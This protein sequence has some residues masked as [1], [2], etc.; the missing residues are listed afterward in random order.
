EAEKTSG[1]RVPIIAMTAQAMAGDVEN[2]LSA[3]MDA[4]LSKPVTRE[5]LNAEID[6]WCGGEEAQA[7]DVPALFEE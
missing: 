2:C 5:E 3:G 7:I 6:R 4:Y 1:K